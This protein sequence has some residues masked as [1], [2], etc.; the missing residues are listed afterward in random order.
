MT[1][2]KRTKPVLRDPSRTP[3]SDP[4]DG[5]R[6]L[7]PAEKARQLGVSGDTPSWR[8]FSAGVSNRPPSTGSDSGVREGSRKTGFV[9][10]CLVIPGPPVFSANH[11]VVGAL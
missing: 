8:A 4:V 9:R 10:F 2:Q 11:V 5:G 3:E 7:T 1:K 6:L